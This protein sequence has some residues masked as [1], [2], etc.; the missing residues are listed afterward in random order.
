MR[1][2]EDHFG[3]NKCKH[4]LFVQIDGSI[5]TE[6]EEEK[7]LG[8]CDNT[9]HNYEDTKYDESVISVGNSLNI[10]GIVSIVCIF[11]V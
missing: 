11:L 4:H 3:S 8:D 6:P 7:I 2:E 5:S 9:S 10:T 1:I